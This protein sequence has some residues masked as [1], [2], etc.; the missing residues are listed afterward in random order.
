MRRG[1]MKKPAPHKPPTKDDAFDL[2]A[3]LPYRLSIAAN[4]VS[5]RIAAAYAKQFG[6]S[7]PEW[8]L[9]A[10]LSARHTATQQDLVHATL[11]DKVAVSRAALSL[12]RKA[13]V[14]RD[15]DVKDARSL[16][17]R[18][19]LGGKRLFARIAPVARA[20]EIAILAAFTPQEAAQL[21]ALLRRLTEAAQS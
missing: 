7:I 11:M 18:L 2:D 1:C 13:L 12:E 5:R 16:V 21:H 17:L 14:S 6:L 10:V 15:E 4:A 19:T 3:F 9:L 8:R 20:H